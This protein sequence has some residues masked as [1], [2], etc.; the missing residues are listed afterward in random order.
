MQL[1]ICNHR[2][3]ITDNTI[4]F[5]LP[6]INVKLDIGEIIILALEGVLWFITNIFSYLMDIFFLLAKLIIALMSLGKHDPPK[7]NFPSGPG[8]FR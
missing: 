2:W 8:T 4:G 6:I 3:Y 1:N 5:I 7:P